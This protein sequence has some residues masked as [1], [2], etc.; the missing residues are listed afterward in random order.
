MDEE[1]AN[2]I[3]RAVKKL[4]ESVP[5][6]TPDAAAVFL[7]LGE[8]QENAYSL[9]QALNIAPLRVNEALE[10]LTKHNLIEI[11]HSDMIPNL[12]TL[13]TRGETGLSFCESRFRRSGRMMIFGSFIT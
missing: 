12:V 3:G 9:G 11:T 4:K 5:K 1:S 6:I 2:A 8:E 7:L 10:D 13:T